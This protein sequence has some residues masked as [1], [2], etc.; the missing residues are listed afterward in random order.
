MKELSAKVSLYP[1]IKTVFDG[2][3]ISISEILMRIKN[4]DYREE[5]D[6]LRGMVMDSEEQKKYK[7]TLPY[8]TPAGIFEVRNDDGL[9]EHSGILI[10]DFDH[11]NEAVEKKSAVVKDPHVL[12]TFISCRGNGLAVGIRVDGNYHSESFDAAKL[13]FD[14]TYQL[15]ADIH[16][17]NVSRPRIVSYDPDLFYNSEAKKF[18]IDSALAENVPMISPATTTIVLKNGSDKDLYI[19]CKNVRDQKDTYKSGNHHHYLLTLAYFLNKVGVTV[20]YALEQMKSDFAVKTKSDKDIELIVKHCYQRTDEHGTYIVNTSGKEP[21]GGYDKKQFKAIYTYAHDL[22]RKG[23]I[24]TQEDVRYSADEFKIPQEIVRDIFEFIFKTNKSEH[25]INDK[26]TIYKV[27]NFLIK[28]FEF[29]K[30]IVTQV[31]EYRK[32]GESDF[33]KLNVDSIYRELQHALFKYSLGDTKSLL[34]SN[35]ITEYDPFKEYFE[36]LPQWDGI[37]YIGQLCS[38]IKAENQDFFEIQFRKTLVRCIACSIG[39]KENRMVFVIISP[40]QEMGKSTFIRYINPFGNKYYTESPLRDDK[41]SEFRFAENFIY[42]IDELSSL[43]H[44]DIN[45]LKAII[46]KAFIKER[47]PYG[48]DEEEHPRRCN[49]FAS[50]NKVEF[51][52]DTVNTRWLLF[53]L[54][55]ID[56]NYKRVDIKNV[57]SQA[58]HLYK[59]GFNFELS[60]DDK[61]IREEINQQYTV[62]SNESD[63]ITK[64]FISCKQSEEGA[65]FWSV[66][67]IYEYLHTSTESKFNLNRVALG[68]AMV[69]LGFENGKK[70]KNGKMF[71]GYWLRLSSRTRLVD[72][73]DKP[74]SGPLFPNEILNDL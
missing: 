32:I 13:Y 69:Q 28:N 18:T 57:W 43:S 24:W 52:T 61:R 5:I 20:A 44:L 17:R 74:L 23:K 34:N 35:F 26:S 11:L 21:D 37:D 48:V 12:F 64:L 55:A 53:H 66:A 39:G 72:D 2:K 63:L 16:C 38:Y 59:T 40:E 65:Q 6:R 25:G 29:R 30:N 62:S 22:N 73:Y 10:L 49:F 4:G 7:R 33:Q 41:D 50:T 3:K 31:R 8:F 45:K 19:W 14:S 36:S 9:I 51:L 60:A 47:K 15:E 54:S 70:T 68:R 67:E 1:N 27:E 71:R 42:N 56:W 58:Y 46:S